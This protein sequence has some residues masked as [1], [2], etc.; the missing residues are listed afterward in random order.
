MTGREP[1]DFCHD[2]PRLAVAAPDFQPVESL[3]PNA[4]IW[5]TVDSDGGA[6]RGYKQPVGG[7]HRSK[8]V[9]GCHHTLIPFQS[10]N[11]A[12][13]TAHATHSAAGPLFAGVGVCPGASAFVS[14][15]ASCGVFTK[16]ASRRRL[17]SR[18]AFCLA[19]T[20]LSLRHF[21]P[22]LRGFAGPRKRQPILRL[23]LAATNAQPKD[24]YRENTSR[25]WRWSWRS[26]TRCL[27]AA[28]HE[29]A[30]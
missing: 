22:I 9:M 16:S 27:N 21:G 30:A 23:L 24:G 20:W 6:Y 11:P 25:P 5:P 28:F 15:V 10:E 13:P 2:G 14:G 17:K 12:G 3:T 1:Q 18:D 7:G 26:S 4:T 8:V 19:G 29:A